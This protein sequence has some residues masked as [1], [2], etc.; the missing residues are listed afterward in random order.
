[1]KRHKDSR[2]FFIINIIK[3]IFAT[4]I[5]I[6]LQTTLLKFI[7]STFASEQVSP[8]AVRYKDILDD[9]YADLLKKLK[10][11]GAVCSIIYCLERTMCDNLSAYL[12]EN[13]IS[14]A[15]NCTFFHKSVQ[16][17]QVAIDIYPV[18]TSQLTMRG[19]MTSCGVPS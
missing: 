5:V 12:S 1:M 2:S 11:S 4:I 9:A 10:S 7:C 15:G 13:G 3:V 16:D 14:C 8:G 17:C 18:S 6:L 19:R